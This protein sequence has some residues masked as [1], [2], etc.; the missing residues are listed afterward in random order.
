MEIKDNIELH[1]HYLEQLFE[2]EKTLRERTHDMTQKIAIH[3]HILNEHDSNISK[4]V[5]NAKNTSEEIRK[6]KTDTEK[7]KSTMQFIKELFEK[8]IH[9]VYVFLLL[10]LI[11]SIKGLGISEIIKH[12]I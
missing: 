2:S 7:H 6:L 4:L 11:E 1:S 8:P 9:W 12:F 3:T 10:I 5:E